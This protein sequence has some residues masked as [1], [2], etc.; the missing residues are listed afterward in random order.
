MHRLFFA[1]WPDDAL[2][3]DI[4]RV[5]DQSLRG[6]GG[7]PVR[8]MRYH[9]TLQFL[10][11]FGFLAPARVD[12]LAAAATQATGV[13]SFDVL[14][15][16]IGSFGTGRVAWMGC[17]QVPAE[18]IQLHHGLGQA[19][20]AAGFATQVSGG[21]VPHVTLRRNTRG[22]GDASIPPL[23]WRVRGFVLVDSTA[24]EYRMLGQWP[25]GAG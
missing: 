14:L 18:L 5:A 9:M 19:L 7:R 11:D 16:R 12:T 4:E 2:R 20:S 13:P 22:Q 6:V 1:L 25:L 23:R 3:R 8:P 15:D 10:G 17:T 24:G 21:F